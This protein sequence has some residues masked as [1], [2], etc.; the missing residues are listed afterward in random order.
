MEIN[1]KIQKIFSLLVNKKALS[2]YEVIKEY[3]CG[4]E[5]LWHEVKSIRTKHFHLKSS[6]VTIR[7][8]IIYIQKL[9]IT[10]Y[11]MLTNT[12]SIDSERERK[13]F[14]HKKDIDSLSQ[15]T[16][17]KWYTLI[18][19]EIYFK[20]NLIKV[21]IA[22]ARWKKL[23]EKRADIKKRDTDMDLKITLAREY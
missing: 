16:K 4:I 11:K 14:L 7:D 12:L 8:W 9:N 5:L 21:K 23:Y 13:L 18:P 19:T 6:F 22:L 17:E 1:K 15:K 2:N 3:E 10:P 20:W